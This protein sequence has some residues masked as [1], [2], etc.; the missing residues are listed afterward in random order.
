M[1]NFLADFRYHSLHNANDV[2]KDIVIAGFLK[3]GSLVSEYD[4]TEIAHWYI[5]ERFKHMLNFPLN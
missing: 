1:R 3:Q 5:C 2:P 4:K